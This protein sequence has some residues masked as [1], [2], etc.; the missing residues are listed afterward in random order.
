MVRIAV[1]S[2]K[3]FNYLGVIIKCCHVQGSV[4]SLQYKN[5]PYTASSVHIVQYRDYKPSST[6]DH[7][8][9]MDISVFINF[10]HNYAEASCNQLLL[11]DSATYVRICSSRS[12]RKL[13]DGFKCVYPTM[14]IHILMH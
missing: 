11:I 3:D 10:V 13:P 14:L 4:P 8:L 7:S 5:T 2:Q 12:V 6:V 1:V 9:A